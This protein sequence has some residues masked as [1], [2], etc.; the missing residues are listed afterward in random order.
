MSHTSFEVRLCMLPAKAKEGQNAKIQF[1]S[2]WSQLAVRGHHRSIPDSSVFVGVFV[3]CLEFIHAPA[4][5]S[6]LEI[7]KITELFC[8][9]TPPSRYASTC[10]QLR[11]KKAEMPKSSFR[12]L[13][14]G[15]RFGNTTNRF[16]C[17]C[18]CIWGV[19]G[20]HSRTCH[21]L[22]SRN[23]TNN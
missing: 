15:W 21:V 22:C 8:C 16:Q 11:Q 12:A 14:R 4:M 10:C 1:S 2:F 3:V 6:A 9:R 13:G 5:S 18:G 23:A 7:Q 20:V 17:V 19:F